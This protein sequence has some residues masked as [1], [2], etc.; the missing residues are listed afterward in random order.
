MKLK[1]GRIQVSGKDVID[2]MSRY[3]DL[4]P[5]LKMPEKPEE[6]VQR[7]EMVRFSNFATVI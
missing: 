1:L 5:N 3:M 4:L 2:L 7:S 6:P